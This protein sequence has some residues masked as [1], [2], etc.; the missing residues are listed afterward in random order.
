MVTEN[1]VAESKLYKTDKDK[2]YMIQTDKKETY[3][4][5]I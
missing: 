3:F 2:R 1:I 5:G 4:G